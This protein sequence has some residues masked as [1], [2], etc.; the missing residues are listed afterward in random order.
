MHRMKRARLV[1]KWIEKANSI[2]L[3]IYYCFLNQML[4]LR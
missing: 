3:W 4:N 1:T 2:A